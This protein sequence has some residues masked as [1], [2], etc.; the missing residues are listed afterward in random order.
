MSSGPYQQ[1]GEDF[2]RPVYAFERWRY[3]YVEGVG[4]QVVFE[5]VDSDG[6]GEYRLASTP[7]DKF[8]P[9]EAGAIEFPGVAAW[10]AETSSS[11]S[12]DSSSESD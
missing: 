9:A 7:E 8:M 1:R 4:E 5:F 12:S 10:S 2:G 3:D 6:T 11:S